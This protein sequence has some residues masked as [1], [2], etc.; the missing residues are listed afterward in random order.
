MHRILG[1][2]EALTVLFPEP[3]DDALARRL[4]RVSGGPVEAVPGRVE[5]AAEERQWLFIPA[6]P[7]AAGDYLLGIG[8]AL[9]DLAGNNPG[10][11][12]EIDL[13][14]GVQRRLSHSVVTLPFAIR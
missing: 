1:S 3:L 8:S 4:L 5:L 14:E 13:F 9:E 7:W 10:K 6:A 2:R 11:A 12:F